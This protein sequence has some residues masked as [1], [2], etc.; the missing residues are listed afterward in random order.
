MGRWLW[1]MGNVRNE[2]IRG[3]TGWSTF[4]ERK[5][6]AMVKWM[7]RV[8]F[9]E[10]LMSEIGRACLVEIGCKSRWWARYRHICSKIE[11]IDLV[12]FIWLRDASVN[13]MVNLRMNVE[14]E[15]WKKRI[16]EKIQWVGREAWKDGFKY[17]ERAKE[18]VKM[19]ECHRRDIFSDGS[20]GA[21]VRLVV[22]RGCL[23]VNGQ[24]RE[25]WRG[26]IELPQDAHKTQTY[27]ICMTKHSHFP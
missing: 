9:E 11:L 14:E 4:E 27:I 19:K 21:R 24:E 18:Y 6:K 20:V 22:R 25:R 5:A 26:T 12:N 13:G 2:L 10:N 16:C 7:L 3:E 23:P 17:T 8:V 15:V 1:D